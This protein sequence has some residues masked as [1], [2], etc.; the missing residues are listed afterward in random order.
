[1]K[2]TLVLVICAFT[3]GLFIGLFI[4]PSRVSEATIPGGA[5]AKL[6]VPSGVSAIGF[7]DVVNGKPVISALAGSTV[8]VSGWAACVVPANALSRVEVRVDGKTV[9]ETAAFE[10][11]P[12]VAEAYGRPDFEKSGWRASFSTDG[13][14]EG[15]HGLTARA[16]CRD[17]LGG[18]LGPFDL[19]ITSH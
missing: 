14:S 12:N 4:R 5:T 18:T 3:L 11:R 6:S 8:Q 9:A 1:M 10:S 15:K 19:L 13:I 7:L 2:S 16:T 17:G